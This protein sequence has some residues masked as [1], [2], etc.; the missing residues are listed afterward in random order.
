MSFRWTTPRM[1]AVPSAAFSA[2]TSG[3]PPLTEIAS[4]R[5]SSSSCTL[6]GIRPLS[7]TQA[8][9]AEPAPL[10]TIDPSGRSSPDMRV[11]AVNGTTSPAGAVSKRMP[12]S[13]ARATIDEPSGVGSASEA[14]AAA[15]SSS[16]VVHAGQRDELA[17]AAVAVRDR[18]GLVEQQ[19][20]DV[21]RRLDR[22]ARHREHVALHEAIHAGDAD[23]REERADRR[24]DEADEQGDEHRDA[25][26]A[27][28]VGRDRVQREH[29]HHEDDRE[30]REQDVQRDLVRRL[31]AR[32]ALDERDHAVDE[33]LAGLRRDAHHDPV[34]EH[35]GAAGDRG[36]VAAGLAHDR[37][38]LAG[39]GRLVHRG[40]ALDDVAVAG[41]RLRP[42]TRR[43]CR[44]AG[45]RP[46]R[47]R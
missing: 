30:A 13:A 12:R 41:D 40:D 18:A 4:T 5:W 20:R 47:P 11:C 31:L 37:G 10:R 42:P 7:S 1:R 25:R 27:R 9:T 34:G 26:R 23:G 19:R 6:E 44:R 2:T 24:R 35:A 46:R 36:A 33:G 29:D 17:R 8:M 22:A 16:V 43:R 45:G 3:V 38:R 21:A 28:R 39:D 15:R 14:S 32:R